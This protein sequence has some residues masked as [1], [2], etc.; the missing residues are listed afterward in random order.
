MLVDGYEFDMANDSLLR[1]Y[2]V[3]PFVF[4]KSIPSDSIK[5]I[6]IENFENTSFL[7]YIIRTA[8]RGYKNEYFN[9]KLNMKDDTMFSLGSFSSDFRYIINKLRDKVLL[10]E[11]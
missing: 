10:Q 5:N 3:Y 2:G 1:S 11:I 4:T 6:E 7:Y 9:L 8:N